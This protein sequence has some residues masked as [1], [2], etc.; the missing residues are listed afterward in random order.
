MGSN[1]YYEGNELA[2]FQNA[3]NW[4]KYF[5]TTILPYI[6]GS[7][8]EVGAGIGANTP[9]LLN[10][11]VKSLTLLE[12]DPGFTEHLQKLKLQNRLPALCVIQNGTLQ[13]IEG[14][15]YYDTILYLDVL[16]HIKDDKKELALAFNRLNAG[17]R[18]IIL[19][20]AFPC[21]FSSFDK[22]IGHYRR[23]TKKKLREIVCTPKE[24]HLQYIDA[25]GFML[26]LINKTILNQKLPTLKQIEFWD[27]KCIPLS[28]LIDP[29]VKRYFGRS[30][31]GVWQKM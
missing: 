6:K 29:L 16:E 4:K 15:I 17:G 19:S 12:P 30:I 23:Y 5:S 2:L 8:L 27:K 1:Y 7:V 25:I 20:P 3:S 28:K 24:V 21:L 11:K 31:L 22:G 10:E 26:S 18:L 14:D 13:Q 9:Y